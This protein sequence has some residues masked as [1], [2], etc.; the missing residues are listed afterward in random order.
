MQPAPLSSPSESKAAELPDTVSAWAELRAALPLGVGYW[1][2]GNV[3]V[4]VAVLF[5][6]WTEPPGVT[7]LDRFARWDGVHYISICASGYS[8][9]PDHPNEVVFFPA[10]PML[11]R[12]LVLLGLA[13]PAALLL[14]SQGCWV[15]SLVVLAAYLRRRYA[16]EPAH[17]HWRMPERAP[18][19]KWLA[20]LTLEPFWAPF[21]PGSPCFWDTRLPGVNPLLNFYLV[22]PLAFAGSVLAV[23]AGIWKGWL[24]RAEW[25]FAAG[26]FGIAYVGIA[27]EMCMAGQARYMSVV[28]PSTWSW[29]GCS[30]ACRGYWRLCCWHWRPSA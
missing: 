9:H 21:T 13:P 24:N 26:L 7:L 16:A 3:P 25:L 28:F 14:V 17:S 4:L 10:Y 18:E 1:V 30:G 8:Y 5:V 2:L 22:N 15:G 19:D 29:D 27:H 6:Y 20:L 23:A 11:A 12:P